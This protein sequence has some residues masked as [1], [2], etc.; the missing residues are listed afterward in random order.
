M[1][2]YGWFR[3]IVRLVGVLVMI[4][5]APVLL[6]SIASLAINLPSF[7]S[8]AAGPEFSYIIFSILGAIIPPAAATAVG[9]YFTFNARGFIRWCMRDLANYCGACGYDIRTLTT[10]RC[11]ECNNTITPPTSITPSSR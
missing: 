2:D 1:I 4:Y 5:F 11:P 3:L 10:N 7:L 9:I 6:M 8:G